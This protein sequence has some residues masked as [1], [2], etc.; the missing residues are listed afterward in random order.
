LTILPL[1]IRIDIAGRS[2]PSLGSTIV[3]LSIWSEPAIGVAWCAGRSLQ[4]MID[5]VSKASIARRPRDIFQNPAAAARKS[6]RRSSDASSI[7]R[8]SIGFAVGGFSHA[9]A[10]PL[11][12]KLRV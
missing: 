6:I 8:A 10:R 12:I 9:G 7:F 3:T 4:A 1:S 2:P 11:T 5:D